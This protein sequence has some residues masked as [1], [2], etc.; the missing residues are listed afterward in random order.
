MATCLV[1]FG[2]GATQV[3]QAH[4][5]LIKR[6]LIIEAWDDGAMHV[7]AH[8]SVPKKARP[9]MQVAAG[10]EKTLEGLL[11]ARALA[12]FVLRVGNTTVTLSEVKTAIRAPMDGAAHVMVHGKI[13]L[14]RDAIQVAIRTR[15]GAEPATLEVVAGR[16]AVTKTSRGTV[17]KGQFKTQLAELD[18]VVWTYAPLPKPDK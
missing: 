12:G 11:A 4:K 15:K 18:E 7:V 10:S 5:G 1:L 16:R 13:S 3:A 8:I 17:A 14:P 9:A 6:G 2:V